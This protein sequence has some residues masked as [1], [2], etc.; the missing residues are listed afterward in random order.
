MMGFGEVLVIA[1]GLSMDALTVSIG[2]GLATPHYRVRNSVICG[3]WFGGFQMLMPILGCLLGIYFAAYI[4]AFDHWIAFV[5]LSLIGSNMIRSAL[6]GGEDCVD[7]SYTAVRMLPMAI[8]TAIDAL[9]VGVTL[10]FLGVNIWMAAPVIGVTTFLLSMIGVRVGAV[11]GERYAGWA[12]FA[13]G[14]LLVL[15]GLHILMKH[16]GIL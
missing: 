7:C 3:L 10:A 5:M 8:A 16:T 6:R 9:A 13:G 11:F 14:V 4:E 12:E 1:L 15:M 2:K